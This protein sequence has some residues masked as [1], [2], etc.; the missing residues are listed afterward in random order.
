MEIERLITDSVQRV[1]GPSREPF[2]A[3]FLVIER[4]L[5]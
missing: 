2:K 3:A 5:A 1:S 4:R